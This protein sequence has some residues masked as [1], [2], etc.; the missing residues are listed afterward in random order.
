MIF[1]ND[2]KTSQQGRAVSSTNSDGKTAYSYAKKKKKKLNP[3]LVHHI[4][5]LT[6][7]ELKAQM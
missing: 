4:Q 5:K 6:R 1:D 7:N 3:Y 2:A